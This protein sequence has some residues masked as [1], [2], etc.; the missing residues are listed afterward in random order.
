MVKQ[1]RWMCFI[2]MPLL[3]WWRVLNQ[4][5]TGLELIW[6]VLEGRCGEL[7]GITSPVNQCPGSQRD[8]IYRSR[9]SRLCILDSLQPGDDNHNLQSV[10]RKCLARIRLWCNFKSSLEFQCRIQSSYF[11][12]CLSEAQM[13]FDKQ[14]RKA[15]CDPRWY[16][17]NKYLHCIEIFSDWSR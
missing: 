10:R 16:F 11:T 2:S 14:S 15:E 6:G 8:S 4:N 13:N 1:N 3:V 9:R 5:Q 17:D 7:S 12:S